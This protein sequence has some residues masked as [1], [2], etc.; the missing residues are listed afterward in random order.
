MSS[1]KPLVYII[2]DEPDT[3]ALFAEI[4]RIEGFAVKQAFGGTAAIDMISKERPH[5]ILLDMMMPDV[6]GIE[7]LRYIR[8][9]PLLENVPVV[10]VS[11]RS[12][13]AEIQNDVTNGAT[14]F[15]LKPV[16]A[17]QL[18]MAMEEAV[19]KAGNKT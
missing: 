3:A 7:V 12:M 17:A 13:P 2:E 18:L 9:D 15:L 10:V 8:R 5:T 6:S 16:G 14:V 19:K 1:E 4:L 11:G